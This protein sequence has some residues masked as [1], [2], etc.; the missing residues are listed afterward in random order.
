MTEPGLRRFYRQAAA[1]TAPG[2]W[3]VALDGRP[4]RTPGKASLVLPSLEFAEAIAEEW[5]SQ[6]DRVRPDTMPLMQLA[7]TAIDRTCHERESTINGI[8]AYGSTDLVCYRAEQPPELMHRQ[9]ALWQPLVEWAQTRYDISLAVTAGVVAVLQPA[10]S[11]ETLR[12][13]IAAA[14]DFRLT[15]LAALTSAAG[16]L[17][18]ALAIAEKRLSA[19]EAV[20]VVL[21]DEEYQAAK[22]GMDPE[23]ERR[24][25]GIAADL[26]AGARFLDLLGR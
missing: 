21:V 14:D 24:N 6:G 3:S 9:H 25:R 13:V 12:G 18:V 17:V 22:W 16:S 23:I 1:V 11:L 26:A 10:Q 8:C 5:G 15:A 20:H 19:A 7:S 4:I 2:G